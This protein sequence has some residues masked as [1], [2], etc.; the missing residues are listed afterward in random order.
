MAK[1]NANKFQDRIQELKKKA[2]EIDSKIGDI[3]LSSQQSYY[4]NRRKST[5]LKSYMAQYK[6]KPSTPN[7]SLIPITNSINER[8]QQEG[9]DITQ[10]VVETP[11]VKPVFKMIRRTAIYEREPPTEVFRFT[12]NEG[13]IRQ[14]EL[15]AKFQ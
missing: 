14:A 7:S 2:S 8:T 6:F 11:T 15:K 13:P 5:Q 9:G 3:S 1:N 12:P 10:I 4:K